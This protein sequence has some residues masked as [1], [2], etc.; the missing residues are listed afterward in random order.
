MGCKYSHEAIGTTAHTDFECHQPFNNE[1][2]WFNTS[3]NLAITD[4]TVSELNSYRGGAY[5]QATSVVTQT[6]MFP[7]T[8]L[9][10]LLTF[11]RVLLDPAAY[12]GTGNQYSLYGFQYQPGFDGAVSI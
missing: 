3:D 7:V 2:V 8:W 10:C 11:I 5:Q 9:Q 4:P 6:S 12:E 1:Y